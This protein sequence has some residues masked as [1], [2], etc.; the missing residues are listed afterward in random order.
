MWPSPFRSSTSGLVAGAAIAFA[1]A[2]CHDDP[3]CGVGDGDTVITAT[4]GGLDLSW[5]DL[6]SSANNDCPDPAAPSGIISLT[7]TGMTGDEFPGGGFLTFC[8][9]RIDTLGSSGHDSV[10]D[11][12][13]TADLRIVDVNFTLGNGCTISR[14]PGTA[15]SGT[16][17]AS[18]VCANGEDPAGYA[19]TLAAL[20]TVDQDCAGTLTQLDMEIRGTYAV[21]AAP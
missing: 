13:S 3:T 7:L 9:P 12:L 20:F 14:S 19:L 16:A 6:T 2:G 18:G 8:I 1:S 10:G 17:S 11:T 4:G 5:V 15:V 21:T